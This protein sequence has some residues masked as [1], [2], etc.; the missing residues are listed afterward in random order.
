MEHSLVASFTI[1]LIITSVEAFS[2]VRYTSSHCTFACNYQ[3]RSSTNAAICRS[4]AKNPPIGYSLCSS[5]CHKTEIQELKT[6][7]DKCVSRVQLT[8][9]MCIISCE[10][11]DLNDQFQKI[12]YRCIRRPPK[13]GSM[14]IH[15]CDH[16]LF[17]WSSDICEACA[18]N[19][20]HAL[21]EHACKN[22]A[23]SYYK[24]ICDNRVCRS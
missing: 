12:C 10:S 5:A 6:I 1:F 24:E 22:T 4:C 17:M 19:P 14:C 20:S 18:F 9:A 7:C 8:D 2:T 11:T 13:T 23:F 3:N 16:S 21:C 15:A